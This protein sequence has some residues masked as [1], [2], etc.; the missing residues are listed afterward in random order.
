MKRDYFIA[1]TGA[2]KNVG[3]FLITERALAL[4]NSIGTGYDFIVRPHWKIL[5]DIDFVN[6]SKGIIILGGPGFQ[7]NMYPGVYKLREDINE[8]KVPVYA[9][10]CGWYGFPGTKSTED[11]YV[12]TDTAKQLLGIMENTKAGMSCRDYQT[13]RTLYNNGYSNVKMTGCPVWYH[14]DSLGKEFKNIVE[15]K[16]IVYT[17]AQKYRFS[18][19]SEVVM[20]YLMERYYNA[21]IIVAFHRGID[22]VDEFTTQEEVDNTI[23]LAKY[24]TNLGLEVRDLSFDTSKMD[25]YDD[26]DFHIGYRVHAH[27]YF[28]SKRLPSVL[29]HED[30]RGVGVSEAMYSPGVNAFKLTVDEIV[31]NN[32]S[33]TEDIEKVLVELENTN[34]DIFN[35]TSKRIDEHYSVMEKY[36]KDIFIENED[37]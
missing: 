12:Y 26:C 3:D 16:K 9:L 8:I 32:E 2:K 11:S 20:K 13:E 35:I 27:I 36:L 6:K 25:F 24:A 4:L 29:L 34:Y 7:R 15:I 37:K 14:L 23:K 18:D 30:G 17:P 1:L 31:E 28:L 21:E 33:I 19:Q 10:G 22:E 5:D